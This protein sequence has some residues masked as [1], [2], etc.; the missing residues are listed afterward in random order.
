MSAPSSLQLLIGH[1]Q[2]SPALTGEAALAATVY[3]GAARRVVG[4]WPVWRTVAFLAGIACLLVALESGLDAYDDRLLS[5]HMVQHLLLLELAPA[6]LL[7]GRPVGLALRTL[8]PPRRR[9]LG[10]GLV[11]LRAFTKPWVCVAAFSTV[12]LVAHAP[13]IFDAAVQHPLLHVGEHVCFLAAGLLLWWPLLGEERGHRRLGGL[14]QFVY[15]I[16]AMLPMTVIGAYLDRDP[17]V[18]YPAYR[19]ATVGLRASPVIDQQQAGAIMWVAGTTM[20]IV[21]GLWSS[22]YAMVAAE[23]RQ[24]RRERYQAG[25][26]GDRTR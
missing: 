18:F 5:A 1:W 23:R 10:R 26:A 15:V 24:Q 22:L 17:T 14:A 3:L 4:G 12:V 21:V 25:L 7:C 8:A 6:L 11:R 13:V 2:L 19:T 20:M 16:V 9:W